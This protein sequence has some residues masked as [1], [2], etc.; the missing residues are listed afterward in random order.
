MPREVSPVRAGGGGGDEVVGR[1]APVGLLP[2]GLGSRSDPSRLFA[3]AAEL[4]VPPGLKTV[5]LARK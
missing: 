2:P 5:K 4:C 3:P 1:G